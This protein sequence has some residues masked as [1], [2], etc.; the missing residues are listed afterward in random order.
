MFIDDFCENDQD[1]PI[2]LSK[3]C[4]LRPAHVKL[5]AST[6]LNV[7]GCIYHSNFIECCEILSKNVIGFPKYGSDLMDLLLCQEPD[8]SCWFEICKEC[9]PSK[10]NQHL[11][12]LLKG[13]ASKNVNWTLW[14]KCKV[15]NR[16]QQ[17]E[18][19]GTVTELL[20]YFKAIYVPFLQH[21]YIK[22]QQAASFK[23]D[24]DSLDEE[25]CVVQA[26]FAENYTCEA[27]QEVQ[28]AH[29][30][31]KQVSFIRNLP[32]LP[33]NRFIRLLFTSIIFL[34]LDHR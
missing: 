16:Y 20:E 7:C 21:S 14:E 3:F 5:V 13:G 8:R 6:P 2:K 33:D 22:L 9:N 30:N 10:T 25:T 31:Q 23:M 11:T 24:L 28:N 12:D 15:E 34:T 26:D 1:V 29:W 17:F 27:Q 4:D 18:K 19:N 32:K